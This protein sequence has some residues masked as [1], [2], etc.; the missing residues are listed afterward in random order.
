MAV[1]AKIPLVN[2]QSFGAPPQQ[3]DQQWFSAFTGQIMRR[4][5]LLSSP[6]TPQR[7]FLM[8]SPDNRVW[9]VS[10]TNSGLL[11]PELVDVSVD[12]TRKE[13]PPI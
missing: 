9:K 13:K 11:F 5:S 3:Y 12:A 10:I 2:E 7:Q 4:L 1:N 6:Y 8:Q